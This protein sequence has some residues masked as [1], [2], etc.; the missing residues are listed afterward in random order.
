M[1]IL[2]TKISSVKKLLGENFL[3]AFQANEIAADARPGHFIELST[4]GATLLNKPISIAGVSDNQQEMSMTVQQEHIISLVIKNIGAGTAAISKF[5]PG[6]EIKIIGVCGNAFP[7]PEKEAILVGG[8]I[9]IPPLYF[10]AAY[11]QDTHF[12]VI[13]GAGIK[14]DLVLENELGK[15]ENVEL[16][17][18]TDDGSK[19]SKGTVIP[20]LERVLNKQKSTVYTC[21]PKP[22]LAAIAKVCAKV[23]TPVYASL[24]AYMGCGIG[25]CMG[26]VV[27]TVRGMERVC[28]EGPVF[29]AEDI[30]W[31][32]L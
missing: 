20:E 26:C 8:G 24:E 7:K 2:N 16:I 29:L 10:M 31:E 18:I 1:K 11:Y 32:E 14:N 17:L 12:T 30:L 9:G 6:D 4:G 28:K 5:V 23:D 13:I 27:P 25:V 19:G 21:G 15:L 22:M 3:I